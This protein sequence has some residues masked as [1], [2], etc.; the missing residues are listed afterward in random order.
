MGNLSDRSRL[1]RTIATR[2]LTATTTD[3]QREVVI[4]IGAPRRY[5]D[6]H[7]ECC[8]LIE[9]LGPAR[10]ETCGGADAFQALLL[11]LDGIWVG[12]RQTGYRFTWLSSDFGA[13]IPRQIP[14]GY[15]DRFEKRVERVIERETAKHWETMLRD[16]K[17]DIAE[18]EAELKTR[19]AIMAAWEKALQ[20]RKASIAS[21]EA[22]LAGQKNQKPKTRQH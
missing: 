5:A 14:I 22:R 2:I 12:L 13:G 19:K 21:W 1:G 17:V 15:G 9:G 10:V 8:F 6:G 11:A 18:C 16:R 4:T 7:W 3:E 20:A